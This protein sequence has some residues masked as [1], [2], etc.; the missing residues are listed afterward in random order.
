MCLEDFSVCPTKDGY[1][2][3]EERLL[4]FKNWEG[5]LEPSDLALAG[6]YYVGYKDIVC[7]FYCGVEIYRWKVGDI[8]IN[9]HL[10]YSRD[11]SYAKLIK[12]R[13]VGVMEKKHTHVTKNGLISYRT[14]FWWLLSI[15]LGLYALCISMNVN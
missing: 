3:F 13:L 7:C 5:V 9:N 14:A 6:F 11:C 1:K 15:I 4:S 2:C 8:P 12:D 10:M